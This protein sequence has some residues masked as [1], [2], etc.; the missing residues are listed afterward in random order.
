MFV[1]CLGSVERLW[2]CVVFSSSGYDCDVICI[3]YDFGVLRD[4]C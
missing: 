1:V 4:W 2:H 3:G